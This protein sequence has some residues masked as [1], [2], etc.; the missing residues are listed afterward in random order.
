ML[1]VSGLDV[2]IVGHYSFGETAYYSVA[3]SPTSFV[4]MII[5]ALM[6]PL[7]PA[8]SALSVQ[9]SSD[10][11]GKVLLRSTRY[12]TILLLLTGL[13]F[14]V[15]GY[16]ILRVWVGPVYALHSVHFLRIL[17][18]A[19]VIRNLCAPYATM[20]VATSRQRVATASAITEGVV[21]L[22]SSIWLARHIGALGV[23]LGTLLGAGAGVAMHF[24]VSMR[25]TQSSVAISRIELFVKGMLRPA[26][27]AIPS[28]LLLWRWWP[29]V[30][31]ISLQLYAMWGG[32][33]LALA[34][35]V[36]LTREDRAFV[37]RLV[38][39]KDEIAEEVA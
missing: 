36:S 14:V 3:A 38:V 4:L 12:A 2:T 21:N 18:L 29:T 5:A 16:L 10:Q 28:L 15:L 22:V 6:G 13:P 24:G 32:T 33:T 30:P 11:M 20:V 26:V 27:I 34:W 17:V 39:E 23:A 25:Y 7:L 35:F 31:S 1:F 19:N 37:T 8:T 9:R